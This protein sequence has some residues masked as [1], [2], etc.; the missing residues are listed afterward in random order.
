M[1]TINKQFS[2]YEHIQLNNNIAESTPALINNGN[3]FIRRHDLTPVIRLTIAYT[4]VIAMYEKQR[5]TITKL[6]NEYQISRTFVYML[7]NSLIE[8]KHIYFSTIFPPVIIKDNSPLSHILHLRLEGRCSLES[9]SS[10]MK[11]FDIE[12]SSVGYISQVLNKIGSQLPNTL[13]VNDEAEDNLQVVFASDEVFSKKKPI[14]ITVDPVS[15]A[16]LKIELV[17]KRTADAWTDH[18]KS[19][20][21]NGCIPAYLV[22]DQGTAL[23]KGH[24]EYLSDLIRQPDTYHAVSHVLGLWDKRFEKNAYD[25]IQK[26]YDANVI[27]NSEM[28]E[29][30]LSNLITKYEGKKRIAQEKIEIYETFHYLYV[31][32]LK[33][34]DIFDKNGNIRDRHIA[35]SNIEVCLDLIE[36]EFDLKKPAN[37]IRRILKDLFNYFEIA[38]VILEELIAK[39]PDIEE[40]AIKALCLAWQWGK[41][42]VKSKESRKKRNCKLKEQNYYELAELYVPSEFEKTKKLVLKELDD[43]VQSSSIVECINSIIRP[44]LNNSKNQITQE[45]LNLIMF[46]HNHRIYYDG[47]RKGKIPYELLTE[48][49]QSK[50]WLDLLIEEYKKNSH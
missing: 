22:C 40:E 48:K 30:K 10:Y 50:D 15:T 6:A 27:L 49:V 47:K 13:S 14:L 4:A 44:Y 36:E 29:R 20:E 9:I 34:L 45:T 1:E 2:E 23:V 41:K 16:I 46:Y 3:K 21:D 11:R 8:T 39:N 32:M 28:D 33:E 24:S 43:I 5:G 12:H 25:A 31:S 7:A 35:E 18:W 37:K 26:E 17:D 42:K 19:I 38:E